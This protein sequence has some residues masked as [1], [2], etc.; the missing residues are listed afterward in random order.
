M[1]V[2]NLILLLLGT[3]LV[4]NLS[5]SC[6]IQW[7]KHSN[8]N[9]FTEKEI[10]L[11]TSYTNGNYA[12]NVSVLGGTTQTNVRSGDRQK[13]TFKIYAASDYGASYKVTAASWT[14]IGY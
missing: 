2:V 14:T 13:T 1:Q 12:V 11:P 7:G 10:T 3:L 4:I 5:N 9:G 6:L 8:S